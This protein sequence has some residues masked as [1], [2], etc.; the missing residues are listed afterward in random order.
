[1]LDSAE[2]FDTPSEPYVALQMAEMAVAAANYSISALAYWS[3]ADSPRRA[4]GVCN[5]W[6]AWRWTHEAGFGA[7][8]HW[9]ALGPMVRAMRGPARTHVVRVADPH[10]RVAAL[11]TTGPGQPGMAPGPAWT[12]VG[13]LRRPNASAKL[14]VS[15]PASEACDAASRPFRVWIYDPLAPPAN[16]TFADLPAHSR[17]VLVSPTLREDGTSGSSLQL[18]PLPANSMFVAT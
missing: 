9:Y 18:G 17:S 10:L 12:V 5:W 8:F 2:Y 3:L 4:D 7:R 6:G 1:M 13:V 16:T 11:Q 14:S 15:L